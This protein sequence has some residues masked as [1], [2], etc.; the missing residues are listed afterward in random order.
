MLQT[1]VMYLFVDNHFDQQI[2][3]F[4]LKI[5]DKNKLFLLILK[6]LIIFI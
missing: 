6:Y 3:I 5:M 4:T 1:G 2:R